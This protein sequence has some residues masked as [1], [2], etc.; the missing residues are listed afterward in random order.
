MILIISSIVVIA[1][2]VGLAC[3]RSRR[4]FEDKVNTIMD[5][6]DSIDVIDTSNLEDEFGLRCGSPWIAHQTC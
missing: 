3:L 5:A 4:K 6:D 1:I 2:G